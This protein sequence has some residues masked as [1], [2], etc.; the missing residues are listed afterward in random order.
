MLATY[1]DSSPRNR[2]TKIVTGHRLVWGTV[3]GTHI[4]LGRDMASQIES[5][6]SLVESSPDPVR[7]IRLLCQAIGLVDQIER[8]DPGLAVSL[9]ERISALYVERV[10]RSAL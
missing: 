5:L 9:R 10:E 6:L 2:V 3:D 8:E 7:T 4:A 1:V